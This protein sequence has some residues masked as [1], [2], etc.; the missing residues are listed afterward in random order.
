M[1]RETFYHSKKTGIIWD[2]MLHAKTTKE[3]RAF[4]RAYDPEIFFSDVTG[5]YWAFDVKLPSG[6][7]LE[8]IRPRAD[9]E[10]VY[11]EVFDPKN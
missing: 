10:Y 11:A 9:F 3:D 7:W 4:I 5:T 1:K 2:V 8:N 6:L